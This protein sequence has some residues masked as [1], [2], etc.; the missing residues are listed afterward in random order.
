VPQYLW[1]D[2][3]SN[4]GR[5]NST[6]FVSGDYLALREL[7]LSYTLPANILRKLRFS[8]LRINL[9]GNNLHYFTKFLEGVNAE[10][11]GTDNGRYPLSKN[12]SVGVSL[13]F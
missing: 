11:G 3:K 6:Y 12:Y 5:G 7:T 9:T 10:D 13:T 1:L 8:N 2:P 4:L